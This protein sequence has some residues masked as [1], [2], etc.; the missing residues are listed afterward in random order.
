[1]VAAT[2]VATAAAMVVTIA[3]ILR[4]P[5]QTVEI[6]E[7]PRRFVPKLRTDLSRLL[8]PVTGPVAAT[9]AVALERVRTPPRSRFGLRLILA[10]TLV[11]AVGIAYGVATRKLPPHRFLALWVGFP[12]VLL[13]AAAVVRAS[14]FLRARGGAVLSVAVAAAVVAGLAVIGAHAWYSH[15][16]GVWLS[17]VAVQEAES[18]AR[19]VGEL[20]QGRPFVVLIGPLG[21]AGVLSPALK[22]RTVRVALPPERQTD[23]HFFV[24]NPAD[25]LA[26]RRTPLGPGLT[27]ATNDY[28][29]DVRTVLPR[30]PP[31]LIV[32]A[33]AEKEYAEAVSSL[34][35][36]VVAPGVA[37]LRGPPPPAALSAASI[38]NPVPRVRSGLAWGL[39]L[40]VLLFV[41]GA[42]WTVALAG[43]DA[44]A[45]VLAGLCPAVGAAVIIL[46]GLAA[47]KLG[48][49]L[50]GVGGVATFS[51]ATLSGVAVA[52]AVAVARGRR[53]R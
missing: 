35:A 32:R 14:E 16:P 46:F 19:Y 22:E 51:V 44:P 42:G 40:I 43:F 38:P 8:W 28:W 39:A 49:R 23:A 12:G 29:N 34:R 4:A 9:G 3:G 52:V 36:R 2:A 11:A 5:F 30:D 13:L 10:W 17:P 15:G 48:V 41:A 27:D 6:Q 7:N 26:G 24:G 33:L 25:L 45:E 21:R 37:L 50:G 20:P 18:A 53:H 1:V 31:V 47:A